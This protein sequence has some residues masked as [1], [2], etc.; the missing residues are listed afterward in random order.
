[1]LG[2]VPFE[3]PVDYV[4]GTNGIGRPV[5][6]NQSANVRATFVRLRKVNEAASLKAGHEIYE[7]EIVLVKHVAGDTNVAANRANE[8]D[9]LRYAAEWAR[10]QRGDS[11]DVGT[12]LAHLY[13]VGPATMAVMFG[14]GIATIQAAAAMSDQ[15]CAVVGETGERARAL[16]QVY[17]NSRKSET[18]QASAIVELK[19]TSARLTELE[20]ECA[21][22]RAEL[23][24]K[25]KRTTKKTEKVDA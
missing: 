10:F 12:P 15:L 2:P 8:S 23:K 21:K 4:A 5:Y 13:G 19:A 7:D 6:S 25:P 22:L 11:V 17:L 24:S 18:E 20:A 14:L 3:L 1:M 9:K 16:A